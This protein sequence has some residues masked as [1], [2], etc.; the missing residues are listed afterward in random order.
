MLWRPQAGCLDRAVRQALHVRAAGH[1]ANTRR[2]HP[3]VALNTHC[4]GLF[5][6][7]R[8]CLGGVSIR[9]ETANVLVT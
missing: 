4:A 9:T 6:K 2:L 8:H 5:V 1:C 3:V 7:M